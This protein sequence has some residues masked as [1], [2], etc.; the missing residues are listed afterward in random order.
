M[1]R[2]IGVVGAGLMGH[3]IAE[4]F[5]MYGYDVRMFETDPA[6]RE[7][8]KDTMA[9]ELALLEREGLVDRGAVPAILDRITVFG[10]MREAMEDRDFVIEAAP[11][12]L[13]LKRSI[14][15]QLD[16]ICP[17][18]TVFASNTSSLPLVEM[19]RD[20]PASRLARFFVNHFYNPAHIMPI[21]E[22]SFFGN[23]SKEL[24][25]ELKAM[26]LSIG[27][28]PVK[29]LKDIPGLIANRIQQGVARE[30]F[31]L[32]EMGAAEPEDIDRALMYGPALRYATTGQLEIADFGGLDI[33]CAVGDN[34]LPAIDNSMKA[35]GLL[36]EKVRQGKLGVKSGEGFYT[37]PPAEA[38]S[39]SERFMVRLIKQLK[40]SRQY[41]D[42]A[43]S[44][45]E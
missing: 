31:S 34:L 45:K 16:R 17:A 12:M 21:V 23:T 8:V 32:I 40:T 3:G 38:A 6:R 44:T 20:L 15:S 30:V 24:F 26:Y 18:G 10:D 42:G 1:I 2:K 22:I 33:W 29:V 28:Q 11:E 39:K 9:R 25:D 5:A 36:R 13:D 19:T 4:A 7:G 35:N 37:Y 43:D 27:K 41:A 14:F